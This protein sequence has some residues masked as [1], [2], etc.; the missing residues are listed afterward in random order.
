MDKIKPVSLGEMLKPILENLTQ[1]ELN[2]LYDEFTNTNN[3]EVFQFENKEVK[4]HK[5]VSSN[6]NDL[7]IINGGTIESK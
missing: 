3:N 5:Y 6:I 4:H 2:E 7:S 1:E